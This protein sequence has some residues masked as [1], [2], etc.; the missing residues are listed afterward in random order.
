M[1]GPSPAAGAAFRR[2]PDDRVA[3]LPCTQWRTTDLSGTPTLAC[4]T[5][6]GVLLRASVAGRV[7]VEAL[8]LAYVA[9]DPAVFRI[10]DDYRKLTPPTV[11][12]PPP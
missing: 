11:K 9:Q 2:G 5:A 4:I 10:P 3:G 1:P 12:H 6:D 8:H 7:L